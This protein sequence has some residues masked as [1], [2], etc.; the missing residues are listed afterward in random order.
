VRGKLGPLLRTLG[1][2]PVD[3][4]SF[5]PPDL[6]SVFLHYYGA[7]EPSELVMEEVGR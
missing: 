5:A 2:L 1:D 3:D 6:E 7:K 4:L